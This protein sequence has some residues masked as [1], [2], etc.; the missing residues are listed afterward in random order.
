MIE[1]SVMKLFFIL[2]FLSF[3]LSAFE[4]Q[5]GDIILISFNCYECRVIEDETN[6]PFSHSGVILLNDKK[7]VM[8]AQSLQKVRL[9]TLSEFLNNK[10]PGTKAA[11]YRPL[12]FEKKNDLGLLSQKMFEVF[13]QDYRDLP[14]DS[15]YKWDNFD[16]NGRE[17]LYCSEF[18]AKFLDNFLNQKTQL[19]LLSYQKNYNFWYH[20]FKGHVPEG[21]LGNSPASLSKDSRFYFI[22]SLN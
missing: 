16:K 1:A 15:D 22:G 17:S 5:S 3:S 12:E 6:S 9:S 21:E 13:N 11:I 7:E 14:F 4:L 8:V 2:F 10:T 20:Y 19:F 18:V